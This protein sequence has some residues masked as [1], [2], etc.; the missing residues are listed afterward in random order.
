MRSARGEGVE[1]GGEAAEGVGKPVSGSS[2]S[3]RF[4]IRA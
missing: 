4:V 1:L 3:E 2:K